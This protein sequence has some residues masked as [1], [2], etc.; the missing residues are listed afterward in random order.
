MRIVWLLAFLKQSAFSGCENT[1]YKLALL[2]AF[3][4]GRPH[5]KHNEN[6]GPFSVPL[7]CKP[8]IRPEI[9]RTSGTPTTLQF[10]KL[11]QG[12]EWRLLG[13]LLLVLASS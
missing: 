12:K 10:E 13:S 4:W 5:K 11:P 9:R 8:L 3:E 7:F 1:V 2:A 6:K